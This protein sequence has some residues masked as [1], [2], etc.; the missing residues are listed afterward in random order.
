M[1]FALDFPRMTHHLVRQFH[2]ARVERDLRARLAKRMWRI[3]RDSVPRLRRGKHGA[4]H[5]AGV[6]P[7]PPWTGTVLL[8]RPGLALRASLLLTL[9]RD[10]DETCCGYH[11]K[12]DL[13]V[14]PFATCNDFLFRAGL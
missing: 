1:S 13:F 12:F 8:I 11:F 6:V 2:M 9:E 4:C 10:A 3:P 5:A 7:A 14:E